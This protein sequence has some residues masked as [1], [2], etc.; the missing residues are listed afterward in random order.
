MSRQDIYADPVYGDIITT[1]N[2]NNKAIYDF[3]FPDEPEEMDHDH[4]CYGEILVPSGFEKRYM[5]SSGIHTR[6]DYIPVYKQL[7]IRLSVQHENGSV[8][9]VLNP[10]N[11]QP[12]FPV[13][14]EADQSPVHLSELA[15]ISENGYFNFIVRD[16]S[17][18][19]FSGNET[20]CIIRDSLAQNETFLLKAFAG[21]LY[22]HPTTG[23]G[24]IDFLHGNFENT[25][26][27]AKL[28]QEFE[29]DRMIINNAYMDSNTGELILEVEEK[30]G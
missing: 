16:G 12:W 7:M 28:Q 5:E 8:E 4:F 14:R 20:D 9:Y 11:N 22:Q 27:A 15:G 17:L 6:I 21:N 25:N 26:L 24:L 19:V 1:D 13:I 23:V 18:Q 10:V 2:L 29:N 3:V 30:N